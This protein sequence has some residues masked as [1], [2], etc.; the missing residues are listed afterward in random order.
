MEKT[1]EEELVKKLKDN[2]INSF[3]DLLDF[4]NNL[5]ELRKLWKEQ[6]IQEERED[7]IKFLL[8]L[9]IKSQKD[10]DN[11]EAIDFIIDRLSK[12]GYKQTLQE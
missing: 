4:N 11:L 9:K 3:P 8:S 7:E 12:L 6:G 2:L 5:K 10:C 1:K